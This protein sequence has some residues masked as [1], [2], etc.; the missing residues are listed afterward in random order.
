MCFLFYNNFIVEKLYSLTKA[1]NEDLEFIKNAKITNIFDYAKNISEG[2][3]EDIL[4]YVDRFNSQF[5]Y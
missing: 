3:Q 2:E 5:N 4:S 1:K